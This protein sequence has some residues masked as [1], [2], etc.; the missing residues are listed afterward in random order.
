[1]KIGIYGGS[2]NPVHKGHTQLMTALVES[3][4]VD[5]I[6]MMV[7]PLNP[8]KKSESDIAPYTHRLEMARLAT[9]HLPGIKVSDFESRLPVPSYTIDTLEAL[10][11]AYPNMDFTLVVGADNWEGFHKWHKWQKLVE[12]YEILVYRRPEYPVEEQ[13]L[14]SSVHVVDTPLYDISATHIRTA[15]RLGK[16]TDEWLDRKVA[17]YIERQGLYHSELPT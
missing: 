6:W 15:L 3:K 4:R 13:S 9:E 1:M 8:L 16:P 11:A 12:Q 14:P 17:A 5:E 10:Q 7:S 2:F